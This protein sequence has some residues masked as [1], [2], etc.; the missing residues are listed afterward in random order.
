LVKEV[1][2]K[3]GAEHFTPDA[4]FLFA[5]PR[6]ARPPVWYAVILYA[7]ALRLP[8]GR[9]ARL[10]GANTDA[11][12]NRQDKNFPVADF[13]GTRA[14]N[15]RVNRGLHKSIVYGNFDAD[16]LEQIHLHLNTAVMLGVAHLLA[17]AHG[18]GYGDFKNLGPV[19][20]LLYLIQRVWLDI[21]NYQFHTFLLWS[22]AATLG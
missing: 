3:G 19:Q 15:N 9:V 21:R 14:A 1:L 4:E 8:N 13:A 18:V 7:L 20:F 12:L 5:S 22:C 16:F 17:A 6:P 2:V 10:A 11:F